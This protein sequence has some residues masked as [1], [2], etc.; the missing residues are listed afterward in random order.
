M[1]NESL[2]K[3]LNMILLHLEPLGIDEVDKVELMIN[4][5]HFLN[6]KEY[7]KNIKILQLGKTDFISNLEIGGLNGRN[8]N[9]NNI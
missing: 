1:Q 7:D 9:R 3:T 2:K 8:N 4:L 5:S 6:K